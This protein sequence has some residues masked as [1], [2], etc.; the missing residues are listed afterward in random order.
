MI[1]IKKICGTICIIC[2][3][4]ILF[5]LGMIP[6][7]KHIGPLTTTET[8]AVMLGFGLIGTG[9]GLYLKKLNSENVDVTFLDKLI[10]LIL[11]F[12]GFISL[13]CSA[14]YT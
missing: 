9:A 2:G 12:S 14:M 11:F 7:V 13:A 3:V 4:L 1:S 8:R 5:L 10:S 6:A